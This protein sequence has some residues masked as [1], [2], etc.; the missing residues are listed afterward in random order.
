M[1]HS[2]A[3]STVV[4]L[5]LGGAL[6]VA[7]AAALALG[8]VTLA[9]SDV[10]GALVD[11]SGTDHGAV[12]VVRTVRV[13]RTVAATL[14]GAALAIVGAQM[15][16]LFRNPLADPFVLGVSS[17]ASF[18]VAVV[19]LAAGT[20]SSTWVG[21]LGWLGDL[22]IAGAA[23][24]GALGA[25]AIALFAARRVAGLAAVLIVGVMLGTL[26]TALVQLLIA[27]ADADRLKQFATWGFGSFRGVTNA[28]L[29]ILAPTVLVG[30]VA[31]IPMVKP[32]DAMMLGD[33]Y[34][35][36]MGV[37]VVVLTR[38]VLGVGSLLAG[39]VTAFAGPIGFVG[40]A[41]PHL[42][43]PL[44][45]TSRHRVV[46]PAAA[47]IGAIITLVAEVIAQMPGR[48]GVLPLNAVTALVGAP[49]VV[50]VLLRRSR[51]AVIT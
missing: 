12:A 36:S 4:G 24:V 42:A 49:V 13:P 6:I 1:I 27:G 40:I 28:E 33:R 14:S 22:G 31:T 41:A 10:I 16:T 29:R 47:A 19:V 34:A 26:L 37:N 23:F 44:V 5:A 9:L 38:V 25:T 50:W 51:Q 20:G 30:L 46:L 35:E 32:L 43:R 8:S 2:R 48:A 3:R 18:G 21:G 39:V 17:G 15:Q 45:G 7:I 11:P